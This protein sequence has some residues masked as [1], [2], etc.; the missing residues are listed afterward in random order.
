MLIPLRFD[1]KEVE[2][3]PDLTSLVFELP[4]T[5]QIEIEM[6]DTEASEPVVRGYELLRAVERGREMPMV[7][8]ETRRVLEPGPLS[9]GHRVYLLELRD[10]IDG[11]LESGWRDA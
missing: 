8:T 9:E 11:L 3:Q 10:A 2:S 6:Y 5:F 7:G 1:I 4:K